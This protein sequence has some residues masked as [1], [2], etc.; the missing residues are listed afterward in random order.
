MPIRHVS[1]NGVTLNN[2]LFPILVIELTGF[3][4]CL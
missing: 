4:N 2:E 1:I 3:W